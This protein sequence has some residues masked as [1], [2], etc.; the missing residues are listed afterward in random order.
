[1]IRRRLNI[2]SNPDEKKIHTF[3]DWQTWDGAWE[4][5]N[6]KPYNMSPAPSSLHQFIVGELHFALRAFF[7]NQSCYVFVAP[8]DI[9]F[10][11]SE[12]YESPDHVTQPDLSVVCSK[13]QI[14][15]NGCLG[16]P[17]LIIEVLSPSTALK[18]F[19]EKFNLYQKYGV[20]EYWIVDPGNQTVHVYSLQDGSYQIRQLYTEQE[21]IQSN[22]F[23]ELHVP[24]PHLFAL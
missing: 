8:F 7:Q 10:S 15:K 16:A 13:D 4:L 17:T 20:Q 11:E 3:Q 1:M 12:N 24:M 21:T 2:V 5:I 6:G 14:T 23:K 18:D 9:F 22:V 19:N